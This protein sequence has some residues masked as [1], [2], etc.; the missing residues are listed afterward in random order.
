MNKMNARLLALEAYSKIIDDKGYSNIV[1]NDMLKEHQLSSVDK[2]LF[3]EIV[4]G[5]ISHK[6]TIEHYLKPFIK[7]RVKRWQR[8]LLHIS[9]YQIIYLERVPDYAVINDAVNIAKHTSGRQAAN[10]TNAILRHFIKEKTEDLSY[11]KDDIKRLSLET[12]VPEWI[13]KQWKTHHGYEGAGKIAQSLTERPKMYIRVN[14]LKM[15]RNELVAVLKKEGHEVEITSLHEDALTVTTGAEILNTKAYNEGLFSVQD[16][17]SMFVINALMPS[18]KDTVLDACS[19]PGGKGLHALEKTPQGEA[20]LADIHPHKVEILKRQANRLQLANFNAFKADATAYQYQRMYDKIIVDAP[21]SGLGVIKRKPEIRYERNEKE[22]EQLVELQLSILNHVKNY[23]KPGGVLVYSTCTIHQME[24]EN[25]AYTFKKSNADFD[26][27]DFH[28][29]ALN[30]TG[31]Y[32]QIL[33]F[34]MGTDGFF[35]A[36]FKKKEV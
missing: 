12:S 20:D 5:T 35:I 34:E 2:A 31:S 14:T 15:T 32:R 4:Y 8:Y 21:C 24:N 17:S 19:A 9:A 36:R 29:P 30:F 23:L 3:T 6:M 11:I 16:V 18:G 13:L 10:T 27:D 1:I 26:F 22:I 7:T 28:I 33:P 25:V